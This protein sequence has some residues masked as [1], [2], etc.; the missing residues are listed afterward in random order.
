MIRTQQ[1]TLARAALALAALA[2]AAACAPRVDTHGFMPNPELTAQI[3]PGEVDKSEVAEILGTPSTVG[4]FE[5]KT[6]Y[7]ITQKTQTFAFFKPEITDQNVLAVHFD[8]RDLV[9]DLKNYTIAEGL[10]I[11]PASGKT[12]TEGNEL[13]LLQQL[14]G[15]IGRFE[16]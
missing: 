11:D 16:K 5:D 13:T 4:T 3:V 1:Q 2:L 10:I 8:D 15:N 12:P 6:W 7:Y 9:A 14:F